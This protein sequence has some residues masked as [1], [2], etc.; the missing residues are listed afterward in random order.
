MSPTMFDARLGL[1]STLYQTGNIE[2]SKE[3]YNELREQYPNNIQ[4][5]N[6]LAWILQEHD[7]QYEDALELANTGLKYAHKLFFILII[8]GYS[9][10]F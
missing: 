9:V 1:A 8:T 3:I 4:V 6:D 5:L 10:N 2:R 7:H